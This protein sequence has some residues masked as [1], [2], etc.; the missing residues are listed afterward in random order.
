[1][2]KTL[3]TATSDLWFNWDHTDSKDY[4]VGIEVVVDG[5][6]YFIPSHDDEYHGFKLEGY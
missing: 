2:T 4:K 6:K 3:D 5:D 1:M